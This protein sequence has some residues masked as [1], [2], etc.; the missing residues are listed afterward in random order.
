MPLEMKRIIVHYGKVEVLKTISMDVQEGQIVALIGANGAGKTTTL[1]VISGLKRPTSGEILYDGRNIGQWNPEKIVSLGI[2]HVPEGR[3]VFPNMTV[4]ENLLLGAFLRKDKKEISRNL[5]GRY[6]QF[7]RLEERKNQRAGSLSGGE[8]QMLAICRALMAQP[9]LML[10]DEPTMGLSPMMV[11]LVADI[12][13][14]INRD[15]VAVLLVEQNAR[16]A[17]RLAERGYVLETGSIAL[18]GKSREL[19][20]NEYVKQA[21]LGG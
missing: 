17:L 13:R 20:D 4:H 7:P 5:A 15:G 12:I 21:Y 8:Q 11:G 14:H 1:R 10:L 16:V 2:V 9:K 18:E 3:R 6:A 19:R